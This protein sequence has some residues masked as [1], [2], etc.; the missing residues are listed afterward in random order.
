VEFYL[1]NVAALASEVQYVPLPPEAYTMASERFAKM[2]TGSGFGGVPE[3]G[4]PIDEILKRT[5]Q[6]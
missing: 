3:V 6:H 1:K 4:L 2:E 5:P